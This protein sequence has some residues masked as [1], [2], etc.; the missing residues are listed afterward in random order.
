MSGGGAPPPPGPPATRRAPARLNSC[1]MRA[2][3]AARRG[4]AC[5]RHG[6]AGVDVAARGWGRR[7]ACRRLPRAPPAA[8]GGAPPPGAP[9]GGSTFF[10]KMKMAFSG[11]SRIR[12]R[13]TYTNCPTV[14]SAGT[15]YLHARGGG[16]GRWRGGG[17]PRQQSRPALAA[18]APLR[19]PALPPAWPRHPLLLVDV[20]DVALLRLLHNHLRP[21]RVVSARPRSRGPRT[22][23]C[24]RTTH[25]DAVWIL[26]PD[27]RGLCH[28]LLCGAGASFVEGGLGWHTARP[29]A[30]PHPAGAPP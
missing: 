10:T 6:A 5:R 19:S 12:L 21:G 11:L 27:A 14:R 26:V 30:R 8:A 23:A 2:L 4:R 18:G 15:R 25:R 13:I 9:V 7:Q 28:A 16:G 22:H 29:Q 20:G 24:G 3:A 1:H 17:V